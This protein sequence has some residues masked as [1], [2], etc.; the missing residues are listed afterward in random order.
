[1]NEH[2][3]IL[4]PERLGRTERRGREQLQSL[5][6]LEP[7]ELY[8]PD[9]HWSLPEVRQRLCDSESLRQWRDVHDQERTVFRTVRVHELVVRNRQQQQVPAEP[10]PMRYGTQILVSA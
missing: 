2:P 8:V 6:V 7:H 5:R 9:K 1:M 10:E 3:A 4:L